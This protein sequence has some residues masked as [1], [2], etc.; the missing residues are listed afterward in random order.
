MPETVDVLLSYSKKDEPEVREVAGALNDRGLRIFLDGWD[1]SPD[2]SRYTRLPHGMTV[3]SI[4]VLFGSNGFKLWSTPEMLGFIS[5]W[6][7]SRE[8]VI[9]VLIPGAPE[10]FPIPFVFRKFSWIDLRR[11]ITEEGLDR[12]ESGITGKKPS[13]RPAS[14][15]SIPEKDSHTLTPEDLLHLAFRLV[16]ARRAGP[17]LLLHLDAT[18]LRE[19]MEG[20][21][22]ESS[23]VE[24]FPQLRLR[25]VATWL[26]ERFPDAQPDP[27]W[28]KW[29]L[30][31][32]RKTLED[33]AA[34]LSSSS[35]A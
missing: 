10:N 14:R 31:T 35:R 23:R 21:L 5:E 13:K 11:G 15:K 2:P 24:S 7:R 4:A 28:Q 32:Q 29:M 9:P 26:S 8:P 34:A 27:L 3:R 19:A 33:L 25:A 22:D 16:V 12:L 6:G 18:R 1:V 30:T 17:D 20:V